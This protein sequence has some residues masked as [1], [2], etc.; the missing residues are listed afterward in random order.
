M[1]TITGPARNCAEAKLALEHRVQ[2]LEAEKEQRVHIYT[3]RVLSVYHQLG[4]IYFIIV[5]HFKDYCFER[6]SPIMAP[7]LM[8]CMWTHY[9]MY[10]CIEVYTVNNTGLVQ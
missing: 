7:F 5:N 3:C 8:E 1:V 4:D 2:D 9:T 6:L 10:L